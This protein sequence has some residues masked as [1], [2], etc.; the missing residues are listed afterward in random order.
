MWPHMKEKNKHLYTNSQ[1]SFLLNSPAALERGV[2]Q[3]T[4]MEGESKVA[5]AAHI[6]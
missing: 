1:A 6:K 4:L 3:V 2:L 5:L